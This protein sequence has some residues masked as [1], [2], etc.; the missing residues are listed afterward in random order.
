LEYETESSLSYDSAIKNIWSFPPFFYH[1]NHN[2]IDL[3]CLACDI[4]HIYRVINRS[5]ISTGTDNPV[6]YS[7][8]FAF[9]FRL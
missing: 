1:F 2:N 8:V 7:Y 9:G 6:S 4:A 3:A 5:S